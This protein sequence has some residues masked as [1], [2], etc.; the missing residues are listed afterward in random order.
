M[1]RQSAAAGLRVELDF[2]TWQFNSWWLWLRIQAHLVAGAFESV[3]FVSG[4]LPALPRR[5][6]IV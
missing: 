1:K 6:R 2:T 3:E 4:P 5:L